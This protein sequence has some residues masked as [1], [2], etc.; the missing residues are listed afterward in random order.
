MLDIF[1]FLQE[2]RNDKLLDL[3]Y[4]INSYLDEPNWVDDS[5][6]RPSFICNDYYFNK[7]SW[8]N[9]R[10]WFHWGLSDP[11]YPSHSHAKTFNPLQRIVNDKL[12]LQKDRDRFWNSL[13]LE[14]HERL[15]VIWEKAVVAF[16]YNPSS[17]QSLQKD[18]IWAFTTI[19]YDIHILGDLSTTE[20]KIVRSEEDVRKDIYAAIRTIGGFYNKRIANDLISFLER[21]APISNTSKGTSSA[22]AQKLIDALKDKK[23]GFAKFVLSCRG[24]G[25]NYAQRFKEA[26][27][28]VKE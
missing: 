4:T 16:G 2:S 17:V 19:L 9:H 7:L 26:R 10:I 28:V 14:E 24:F 11:H 21:E 15:Q 27:L 8:D 18:Q 13:F 3:Y 20:Y 5:Y 23:K 6:K 1:P 25:Y 12:M 22:S